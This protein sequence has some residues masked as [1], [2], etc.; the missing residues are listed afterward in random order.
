MRAQK[1]VLA[2]TSR[3]D[4]FSQNVASAFRSYF[5]T[6]RHLE[7]DAFIDAVRLYRPSALEVRNIED[8]KYSCPDP[9]SHRM[10]FET[11]VGRKRVRFVTEF[12]SSVIP[13]CPMR[14]YMFFAGEKGNFARWNGLTDT[15]KILCSLVDRFSLERYHFGGYFSGTI[16]NP[17]EAIADGLRP[18]GAAA[19]AA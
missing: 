1:E 16:R 6:E 2:M 3:F 11:D 13:G 7:P 18:R 10:T 14:T 15:Q 8:P 19:A 12:D 9:A 5:A 17:G 4:R